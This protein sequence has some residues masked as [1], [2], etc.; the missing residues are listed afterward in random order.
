VTPVT[1][2]TPAFQSTTANSSA[3][4]VEVPGAA[5]RDISDM[6]RSDVTPDVTPLVTA[7]D[8]LLAEHRLLAEGLGLAEDAVGHVWAK[9]CAFYEGKA[10]SMPKDWRL[11]CL[12]EKTNGGPA[13]PGVL[14]AQV[15]KAQAI[16]GRDR[17]RK[18]AHE[19]LRREAVPAP[20]A[21][22]MAAVGRRP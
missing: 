12:R 15:D 1:P 19:K 4:L 3:H 2:V 16:D 20:T 10:V 18:T 17:E 6:S 9:F 14:K 11:W 7:G 22:L 5:E 8:P 21:A 13:P